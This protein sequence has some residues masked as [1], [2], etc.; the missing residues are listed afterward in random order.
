MR[1]PIP[2]KA[3]YYTSN[4]QKTDYQFVA[5]V[6]VWDEIGPA[7]SYR[8]RNPGRPFFSVFNFTV[9]H[10]SQIWAR[11]N[12]L[13]VDPDKVT[14]PPIYPDTP[15]IRRDIAGCSRTS[16]SW[17]TKLASCSPCSRT[18]ACTTTPTSFSTAI[19]AAAFPG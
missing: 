12:P 4:N 18:M 13:H 17:T 16:K 5:P 1:S 7:A 19:T 9:T 14:V 15:V 2:R 11:K 6:T 10:E 3:G 8:N